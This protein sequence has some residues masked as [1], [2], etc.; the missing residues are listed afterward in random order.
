VQSTDVVRNLPVRCRTQRYV[1]RT[2]LI[3]LRN[4]LRRHRRKAA[5]ALAVLALGFV[6]LAAH[7]ALMSSDMSMGH[8]NMADT[9]A[10]CVAVG[11]C[12]LFLAVATFAAA[13]PKRRPLWLIA[14]PPAPAPGFVPVL[15]GFLVRA[16]PPP[17]TQVFRL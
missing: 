6:G 9:A 15:F 5:L 17:L 14:P 12:A 13:R 2:V 4:Q 11:G 8:H 10:L 3:S 16:G 7:S 1:H